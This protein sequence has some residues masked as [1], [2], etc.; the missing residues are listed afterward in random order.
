[1]VELY[2]IITQEMH[3]ITRRVSLKLPVVSPVG[4]VISSKGGGVG[5]DLICLMSSLWLYVRITKKL[6]TNFIDI[7]WVDNVWNEK[8]W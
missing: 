1:L 5:I 8:K 2:N 6:K 4:L 7:F 3:R